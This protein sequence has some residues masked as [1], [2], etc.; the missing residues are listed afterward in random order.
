[1]LHLGRWEVLPSYSESWP[2]LRCGYTR[3]RVLNLERCALGC[4]LA[5]SSRAARCVVLSSWPPT[6]Q[7]SGLYLGIM[8]AQSSMSVVTDYFGWFGLRALAVTSRRVC[9]VIAILCGML[10]VTCSDVQAARAAVQGSAPKASPASK[11]V[12]AGQAAL[13]DAVQVG[14]GLYASVAAHS[15]QL[16]ATDE[17]GGGNAEEADDEALDCAPSH[18]YC[19]Q[20]KV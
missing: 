4:S 13:P 7:V 18:P 20:C 11:S 15:G 16:E 6:S 5:G 10:V 8:L 19:A 1:M 3:I 2:Q 17:T 14:K 9:G 12:V